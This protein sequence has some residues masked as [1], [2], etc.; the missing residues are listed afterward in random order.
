MVKRDT[1]LKKEKE[2]C[3]LRCM[4]IIGG[5]SLTPILTIAISR[6][7]VYR[8]FIISYLYFY[9]LQRVNSECVLLILITHF[10]T[11]L[12]LHTLGSLQLFIPRF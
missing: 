5:K 12:T 9:I 7:Q 10:S 4:K 1:D 8:G 11:S 6:K 3:S 2:T